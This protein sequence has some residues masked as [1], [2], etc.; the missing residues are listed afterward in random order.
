MSHSWRMSI[1]T[2]EL[3]P[4]SLHKWEALEVWTAP[5]RL[6]TFTIENIETGETREVTAWNR[7]EVGGRIADGIARSPCKTLIFGSHH[8]A[9][10]SADEEARA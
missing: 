1:K 6:P 5:L 9:V 2:A 3:Y 7:Q 4:T 10:R 8:F